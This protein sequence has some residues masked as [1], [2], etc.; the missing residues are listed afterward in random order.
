MK[1]I[2]LKDNVLNY[3]KNPNSHSVHLYVNTANPYITNNIH[4]NKRLRDFHRLNEKFKMCLGFCAV[5]C[6]MFWFK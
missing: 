3:K 5:H 4:I 6:K 1:K 2:Y